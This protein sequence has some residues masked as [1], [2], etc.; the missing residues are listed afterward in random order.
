MHTISITTMVNKP[1]HS[2]TPT[3]K[4]TQNILHLGTHNNSTHTHTHAY[5]Y[6]GTHPHSSTHKTFY[7]Q[8]HTTPTDTH[9][10]MPMHTRSY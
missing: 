8:G 10:L 9:T 6:S 2:H 1:P 7:T 3:L 5:M 4:H